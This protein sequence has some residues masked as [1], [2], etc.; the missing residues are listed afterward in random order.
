MVIVVITLGILVIGLFVALII[1]GNK[2]LDKSSK[3][4]SP[5]NDINLQI[6][7]QLRQ[8]RDSLKEQIINYERVV[9]SVNDAYQ[10]LVKLQTEKRTLTEAIKNERDT[11]AKERKLLEEEQKKH[12]EDSTNRIENSNK[13]IEEAKQTE[14]EVQHKTADLEAKKNELDKQ[15]Q[16]RVKELDSLAATYKAAL[17]AAE[18]NNINS[19]ENGF[20]VTLLPQYDKMVKLLR[21]LENSYPD[22]KVE[23]SKIEWSKVWMPQFQQ[24]L[25]A[26]TWSGSC[27]YRLVLKENPNICYVGQAKD[28]KDRW[29]QHAKKMLGVDSK[30]YERL[31]NYH[32]EDFIWTVIEDKVAA[33]DLDKKEHY[34]IEHY[35]CLSVGLN[36][37]K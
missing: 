20:E 5:S 32:P 31:Y 17:L 27:I 7:A 11:I 16:D 21:E 2:N 29:Y 9:G 25:K 4:D 19:N 13:A 34:W 36:K 15:I 3:K 6:M 37:R 18:K 8:E 22:L 14:L 35:A 1:V 30:G 28:L 23:L 10:Q 26:Q 33:A 24:K 12:S